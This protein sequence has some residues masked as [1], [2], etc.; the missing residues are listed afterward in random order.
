MKSRAHRLAFNAMGVAIPRGKLVD[1]INGDTDDNRWDNLRLADKKVN[2][3]N[4]GLRVSNKTG[5]RGV[6]FDK[7]RNKYRA[8]L[9]VDGRQVSKRFKTAEEAG[10]W[11]QAQAA[12]YA[13]L[14]FQRD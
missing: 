5:T 6:S 10:A 1:H 7:S 3:H 14:Q 13:V 8:A 2:A 12:K 9:V 4:T 11:Y